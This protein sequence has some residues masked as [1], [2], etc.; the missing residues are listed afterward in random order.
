[1]DSSNWEKV[2]QDLKEPFPAR[3]VKWRVGAKNRENT[4]GLPLAY[5]DARAVRQRLDDVF[6][7]YWQ[8]EYKEEGKVLICRIGVKV[9]GEWLWRGNG[10]GETKQEADKGR[11]SDSFKRAATMWGIGVYLYEVGSSWLPI[12]PKGNSYVLVNPPN[13]PDWATPEGY[14][15]LLEKKNNNNPSTP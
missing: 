10:A 14:R 13:L 1:M 4:T 9:D 7:P 6:G 11:V 2:M 8:C 3:K 15:I 5:V 12:K